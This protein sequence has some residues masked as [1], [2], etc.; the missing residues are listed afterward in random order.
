MSFTSRLVPLSILC[1]AMLTLL[2]VTRLGLA[3]DAPRVRVQIMVFSG[4]PAPEWFF[5]DPSDLTKLREFLKGLPK[6]DPVEDTI[7]GFLLTADESKCRF[8]QRVRVNNDTIEVTTLD[9]STRYFKDSKGLATF[10]REEAT[11]R[12]L[13]KY[14]PQ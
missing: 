11:K 12:G 4:R 13:G 6:A 14:L 9:G 2:I 3:Q 10:L 1:A 7:G 5:E 8:P